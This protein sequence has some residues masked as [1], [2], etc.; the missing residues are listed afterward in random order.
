MGSAG[1]ADNRGR[2]RCPKGVSALGIHGVSSS[3]C[4]GGCRW[5]DHGNPNEGGVYNLRLYRRKLYP[6]YICSRVYSRGCYDIQYSFH[7]R[8]GRPG[9][10]YST[11]QDI[12]SC[13]R[14]R[15]IRPK[16]P[17]T[18][19]SCRATARAVAL[20]PLIFYSTLSSFLA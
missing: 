16:A 8:G 17:R 5:F 14:S 7:L 15:P 18:A 13:S 1:R 9:T 10:I 6:S 12:T 19:R 2:H 11:I 20:S 4:F 3:G